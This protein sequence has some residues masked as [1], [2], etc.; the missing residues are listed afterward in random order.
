M[1]RY[2]NILKSGLSAFQSNSMPKDFTEVLRPS[3]GWRA[4]AVSIWRVLS[5]RPS[6]FAGRAGEPRRNP[7]EYGKLTVE[8][9]HW[10]K[11]EQVNDC[12]Y[13]TRE[14]A[15]ADIFEY[16]EAHYNPIRRHPTLN[17]L[18]PRDFEN[19]MAA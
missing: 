19:R 3:Y 15:K 6:P 13:Q 16:I 8:Q 7:K 4:V 18:S 11:V 10:L 5:E 2:F 14:E 12:R 17:Y 9:F 1:R